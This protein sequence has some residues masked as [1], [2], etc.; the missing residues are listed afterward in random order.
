[1][2]DAYIVGLAVLSKAWV[3]FF[4]V[5][6]VNQIIFK[7]KIIS[8]PNPI[9]YPCTLNKPRAPAIAKIIH[10]TLPILFF[11]MTIPLSASLFF[12]SKIPQNVHAKIVIKLRLTKPPI[13]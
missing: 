2:I 6:T 5:Y 9:K 3:L 7:T 8:A 12:N 10:H 4:G 13:I 1:M 11:S